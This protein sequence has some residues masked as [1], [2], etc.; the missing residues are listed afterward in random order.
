[1][2]PN[3]MGPAGFQAGGQK[4]CRWHS[5]PARHDL[6]VSFGTGDAL[7][8][9]ED[10]PMGHGLPAAL[11]NRHAIPGAR[12]AVDRAV[13][14]S[15]RALGRAPD[16]SEVTPLKRLAAPPVVGE[17]RGQGLVCGA[18]FGDD[19]PTRRV[20]VEAVNNARPAL[21]ADPRQAI[22]AVRDQCV[23]QRAGP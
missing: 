18:V 6:L 5:G 9:L 11:A 13:D 23:D 1:M 3:L 22:A 16:E 17:L 12:V 4:T 8:P 19:H 20:L 7:I 2:D 10:L 21:A 14:G 15:V